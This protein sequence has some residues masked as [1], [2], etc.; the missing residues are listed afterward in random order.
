MDGAWCCRSFSHFL[1]GDAAYSSGLFL[2]GYFLNCSGLVSCSEVFVQKYPGTFFSFL[3]FQI[4]LLQS[5]WYWGNMSWRDAEK[6]LLRQPPGTYLVRD[7]ASDRYVFTISY[8]TKHSVHHTRLAQHGGSFC[9]G[10]TFISRLCR[11]VWFFYF[12]H[13]V[14]H[15][16]KVIPRSCFV[17]IGVE[18]RVTSL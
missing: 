18:F 13:V 17:R 9:L 6:V 4:K 10:G 16:L 8:C 12:L 2:F 15:F 1:T 5:S 14:D 11:V 7:S 3:S